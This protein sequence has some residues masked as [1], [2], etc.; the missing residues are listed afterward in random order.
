[1]TKT[2][3]FIKI[4]GATIRIHKRN[5]AFIAEKIHISTA[6]SICWGWN[7]LIIDWDSAD[8][9]ELN[10]GSIKIVDANQTIIISFT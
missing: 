8:I 4:D 5:K 9:S 2:E 6:D 3:L 10:N 7:E 1:M